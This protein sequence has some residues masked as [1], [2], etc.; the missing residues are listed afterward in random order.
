M[1]GPLLSHIY[2]YAMK[3]RR[4]NEVAEWQYHTSMSAV[5]T[6][7]GNLRKW[8]K[9][10]IHLCI[11]SAYSYTKKKKN[12]ELS[13]HNVYF[14]IPKTNYFGLSSSNINTYNKYKDIYLLNIKFILYYMLSVMSDTSVEFKVFFLYI[15][16]LHE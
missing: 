8:D 2:P 15:F 4:K 7:Q 6:L 9:I 12:L 13:F 10:C 1:S 16:F 5:Q 14:W 3:W 11:L